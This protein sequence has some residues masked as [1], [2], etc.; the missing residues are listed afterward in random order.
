[1][2]RLLT[3]SCFRR[4]FISVSPRIQGIWRFLKISLE[5]GHYI[6]H[7]NTAVKLTSWYS[8]WRSTIF[9]WWGKTQISVQSQGYFSTITMQYF[10]LIHMLCLVNLKNLSP[11][12][13]SNFLCDRFLWLLK[14]L[15]HLT[16]QLWNFLEK[17][18]NIKQK[19]RLGIYWSYINLDLDMTRVRF[20]I[21]T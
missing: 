20:L 13:E 15:L 10:S 14:F 19:H 8:K 11:Q 5:A 7:S 17:L 3:V 9:W 4:W 21:K 12:L 1:M 18:K 6:I 16:S 2:L